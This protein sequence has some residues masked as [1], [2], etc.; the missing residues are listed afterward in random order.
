MGKPKYVGWVTSLKKDA[1]MCQ[2]RRC[3]EAAVDNMLCA[4][5]NADWLTSD[6]QPPMPDYG[7]L[8]PAVERNAELIEAETLAAK[9]LRISSTAPLGSEADAQAL[10]D[11]AAIARLGAETLRER[12]RDD[13]RVHLEAIRKIEQRHARAIARF[14]KAAAIAETRLSTRPGAA[15]VRP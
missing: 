3:T 11:E 2:A 8:P 14:E 15:T 12:V 6:R 10:A 9:S 1:S 5:H 4:T 7:K 13:V